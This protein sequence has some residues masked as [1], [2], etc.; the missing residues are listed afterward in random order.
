MGYGLGIDLGTSFTSAAVSDPQG[1][2]MVPLSHN[3]IVPSVACAAPDGSVLTGPAAL[4][5]AVDPG[6][7]AREFK[8]RLGDPTPL[9]LGG[10]AYSPASLMAA[11]LRD[12]LATVT[13]SAGGPPA[14]IV[15]TCP[16]IWGSYRREQFAE[17]PR[18]A[19]VTDYELV[20][21]PEAAATHYSAER[22]LGDGEVVAVYDLGGGTFDT[23]ILRMR[24]GGMEILGT[25]EGIEHMGGVD[26]DE[27]LLAHLD[28]RLDGAISALDPADPATEGMLEEIHATCVRAKEELS[29]EPDVR[30]SVPLP[31]G[32]RDVTVSR[33][34]FNAMIRPSVRQTTDALHRTI[35]SAGL[36]PEDLSAVLL[37]GG[38]SRIPLVSQLV[39]Q[40]FGKPVR[41]TLHPKF[42]VALGAAAVAA[43]PRTIITPVTPA[44]PAPLPAPRRKWL[45]PVT[46]AA[47]VATVGVVTTL[48]LISGDDQTARTAAPASTTS[49]AAA[50]ETTDAVPETSS[51]APETSSAP[52]ETSD[53]VA[54]TSPG[55]VQA[56]P[57]RLLDG[58]TI[59]PW[60]GLVSSE[61]NWD[62]TEISSNGARQGPINATW[63]GARGLRVTWGDGPGEVYLESSDDPQDLKSYVDSASA[64]V[65][66]MTVH[67]P[68]ADHTIMA[69]NC[70]YPCGGEVVVTNLFRNLEPEQPTTIRIPLSCFTDAGLDATKVDTPFL[71][72]TEQPFDA[73][74]ADIRW[75]PGAATSPSVTPCAN[76]H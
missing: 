31:S 67:Q 76:L 33:L 8:R 47:V 72:Y 42:T 54:G 56:P 32:P 2:R 38:S 11:Q 63:D 14:S 13:R 7:V 26:F 16:A 74:F 27:T 15:L 20:T 39:S 73:T 44:A 43:R 37:A 51:A 28:D 24:S 9:V 53:G 57:L 55:T 19:G 5:A 69:V 23:T 17:V 66:T 64:L 46:A 21:E 59:D 48:V 18:L 62:G 34:E 75:E 49:S 29:I 60:V 45:V 71:V 58:G 50:A 35:G 70:N 65:F 40:E 12:V 22:R 6:R 52:A 4:D 1:T 30:L 68:P 36:R 61:E 10:A 25:P 3:V 41:V